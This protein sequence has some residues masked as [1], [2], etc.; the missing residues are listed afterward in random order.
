MWYNNLVACPCGLTTAH[1]FP[2]ADPPAWLEC[3]ACGRRSLTVIRWFFDTDTR[4][5]RRRVCVVTDGHGYAQLWG[6]EDDDRP[7]AVLAA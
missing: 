1:V 6:S 2:A 3:G 7:L 4:F 5:L